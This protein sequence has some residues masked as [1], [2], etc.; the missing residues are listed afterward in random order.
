M[1]KAPYFKMV[2][3]VSMLTLILAGCEGQTM[4]QVFGIGDANPPTDEISA[5][6]KPRPTPTPTPPPASPTPKPATAIL[7]RNVAFD[8]LRSKGIA[9]LYE[10][11]TDP[12]VATLNSADRLKPNDRSIQIWLDAVNRDKQAIAKR[13]KESPAPGAQ[14]FAPFGQQGVAGAPGAPPAFRPAGA[15]AVPAPAPMPSS[16]QID[17]RLVF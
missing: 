11:D 16:T 7:K 9:Q 6:P 15:P 14:A 3:R 8:A 4:D 1:A 17:P 13:L 10:G 12:A 2:L 5:P